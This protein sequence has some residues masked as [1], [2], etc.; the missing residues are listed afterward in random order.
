[1]FNQN[2][3]ED[4]WIQMNSKKKSLNKLRGAIH[5]STPQN[6]KAG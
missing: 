5:N 3:N 4:R 2:I 6:L 1:M